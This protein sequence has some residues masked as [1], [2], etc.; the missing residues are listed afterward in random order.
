MAIRSL[1]LGAAVVAWATSTAGA[2]ASSRRLETASAEPA[3]AFLDSVGVNTHWSYAD[4]P[5]GYAYAEVRD[6]LVASSIRHMRAGVFEPQVVEL[7]RLG[8]QSTVS[9]EPDYGTIAAM[10]ARVKEL[11]AGGKAAVAG[12][13]GPN[14]PDLFWAPRTT[15]TYRGL[16]FPDGP[17]QFL[18]D[19]FQAINADPATAPVPVIGLSSGTTYNPGA[20]R[21]NVYGPGSLADCVDYGN[22]HP[23][24]G[25]NPFNPGWSY[26]GVAKYYWQSNFPSVSLDEYPYNFEVHAAPFAPK[27][28]M[29]TETGYP[30]LADET[31]EDVQAIYVPR[32]FAENFRLGIRRTFLYELVDVDADPEHDDRDANFGLIR[33]DLSVKPAY[34]ALQ[35]LLDTVRSID[36]RP[37]AGTVPAREVQ[38]TVEPSGIWT[39]TAYAHQILLRAND[40]SGVLLFWH[41]ATAQDSSTTPYRRVVPDALPMRIEW[42]TPVGTATVYAYGADWK[43]RPGPPLSETSVLEVAAGE[44]IGIVHFR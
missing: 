16:G 35:S 36:Q 42:S 13:E 6:L 17:K 15:K 8:V 26:G 11:N 39:K 12:V 9:F 30:T 23:Y 10:V 25:G 4:T 27:P 32:L 38:I 31:P 18:C 37:E 22:F 7:Y 34:T 43:L 21:P 33:H 3:S 44:R 41:E 29:A 1:M 24:A 14:E 40:G 28:M 20:G 2:E 5:Y 19:V